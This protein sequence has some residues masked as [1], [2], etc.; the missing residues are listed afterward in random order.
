MTW[1]VHW[2]RRE[3]GN[4]DRKRTSLG[5]MKTQSPAK[6]KLRR[7][8]NLQNNTIR[9]VFISALQPEDPRSKY[10]LEPLFTS[11]NPFVFQ[12]HKRQF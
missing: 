3:N 2:L 5:P 9:V 11:V 10:R 7:L 8:Y 1:E 6:R 4:R 12:A